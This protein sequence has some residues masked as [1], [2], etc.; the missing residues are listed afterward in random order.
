[1]QSVKRSVIVSTS[2]VGNSWGLEQDVGT[3]GGGNNP[4]VLGGGKLLCRG[5]ERD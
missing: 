1:M 2:I 4:V 3:G 5:A